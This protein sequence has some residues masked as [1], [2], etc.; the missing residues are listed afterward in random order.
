[1]LKRLA[2]VAL[3]G[4][5]LASAKSYTIAITQPCQAGTAQLRP[6]EYTVKLEA[7]KVVLIDKS[8]NRIET[9]A[10]I[11]AADQKFNQTTVVTSGASGTSRIQWIALGG[12]KS[13]V[14]FE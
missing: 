6:G 5:S 3:L 14:V 10:K 11:E 13:K 2:I 8:G 7:A 12:S 9:T 4:V 1:M